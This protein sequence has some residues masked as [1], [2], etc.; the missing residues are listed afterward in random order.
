MLSLA[1]AACG[2]YLLLDVFWVL[3]TGQGLL[4][5]GGGL[6]TGLALCCD[7]SRAVGTLGGLLLVGDLTQT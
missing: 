5:G 6:L 1:L 4:L 7:W 2:A 3:R